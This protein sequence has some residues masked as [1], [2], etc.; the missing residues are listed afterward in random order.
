MAKLVKF[1]APPQRFRRFPKDVEIREALDLQN[2]L[3]YRAFMLT[4]NLAYRGKMK[5]DDADISVRDWRIL[6]FLASTG[7]HTNREIAD[8]MGMD[9]A[10][11]SRAVQYLKSHGL[12]EARRSKRDRRMLLIML[13]QKGADAHD[14]IAPERKSF[15]EEVE[16]CLTEEERKALYNAF[17]KIDAFFS[18]RRIE[19]DEWE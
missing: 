10:T 14:K 11:I 3:P 18:A 12:I 16:S 4:L 6:S 7:P 17:D 13:T 9:S 2:Y 15:S 8:A 1:P 5:I 19:H